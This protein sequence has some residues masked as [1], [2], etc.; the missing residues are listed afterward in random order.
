MMPRHT[1]PEPPEYVMSP[2][3]SLGFYNSSRNEVRMSTP[4]FTVRMSTPPF[5]VKIRVMEASF[6]AALPRQPYDYK[7]EMG[8]KM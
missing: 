8:N 6:T 4:P 3:V 1:K 5:T 2:T 7:R